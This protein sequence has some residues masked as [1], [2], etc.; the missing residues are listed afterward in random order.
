MEKLTPDYKR[1]YSDIINIKYPNKKAECQILLAKSNLSVFDIIE[2]NRIIFGS[3]KEKDTEKVNQKHRSY[4]KSDI[5][6]MLNYQKKNKL[7]NSQLAS[8]FNLSRNSIAK[9]KK[10]FV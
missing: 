4:Q 6:K 7:N 5:L 10:M 9:W 3:T 1:I 2:L 8:H